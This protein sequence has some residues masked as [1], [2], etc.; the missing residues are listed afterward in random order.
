MHRRLTAALSEAGP[1]RPRRR[2][3]LGRPSAS[4]ARRCAALSAR[5]SGLRGGGM[6]HED[7]DAADPVRK[8]I[9]PRTPPRRISPSMSSS[10]AERP[11]PGSRGRFQ[12]SASRR[13]TAT[14]VG[15]RICREGVVGPRRSAR[16]LGRRCARQL[17]GGRDD[18]SRGMQSSRR[19]PWS[20]EPG[21]AISRN[22]ASTRSSFRGKAGSS[23]RSLT[24]LGGRRLRQLRRW[25]ISGL[26]RSMRS[27]LLLRH[28]GY[29]AGDCWA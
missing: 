11:Y 25:R 23:D 29:R 28:R 7:L 26:G 20:A 19:R 10:F 27:A 17:R 16:S 13:L 5:S 9:G 4:P 8:P 18:R 21:G 12:P 1:I 15:D 22:R 6:G 24:A 14:A 3:P 2:A